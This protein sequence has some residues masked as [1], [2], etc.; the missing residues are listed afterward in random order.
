MQFSL[1]RSAILGVFLWLGGFAS[2][3]AAADLEKLLEE[4]SQKR[5]ARDLVGAIAIYDRMLEQ[6]SKA[7]H[8][9]FERGTAKL[10]SG[11][12]SGA[13]ADFTQTIRLNPQ[14]VLAYR[15]RA[16]VLQEEKDYE[17]AMADLDRAVSIDPDRAETYTARGEIR[18]AQE[19]WDQAM[20]EFDQAI[21]LGDTSWNAYFHR[22]RVHSARGDG[23][24]AYSDYSD[25]L[26][27][28]PEFAQGWQERAW[29]QFGNYEWKDAIADGRRALELKPESA[30]AARVIGCSH[31][32]AR[33]Y[34]AAAEM[35]GQAADWTNHDDHVNRALA[36]F[37]RHL[38]L[39]RQGAEDDRLKT[40]VSSW[41][42]DLWT[43]AIGRYLL[44]QSSEDE[45][46]RLAETGSDDQ[47][48]RECE[49]NFFI[50]VYRLQAGDTSTARLRFRTAVAKKLPDYIEQTLA[51][52][53][54]FG[55]DP[56]RAP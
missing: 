50:G 11:D 6:D 44:G 36:L 39:R 8:V 31:F 15:L 26:E 53:E 20:A 25:A 35:L 23:R 21:G 9:W 7:E 51:W 5:E 2:L 47:E 13:R 46:D 54:L 14:H 45:L 56:W 27:M 4:A 28:N 40:E 22:A 38:A 41:D 18:S 12:W 55:L 52:N 37:L 1:W 19:R 48:G 49:V 10:F 42:P 3:L 43:T 33:D 32:G 29:L 24:S 16:A 34:A 17:N 30:D